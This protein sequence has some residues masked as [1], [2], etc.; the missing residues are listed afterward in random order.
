M[1]D[2]ER[3]DLRQD[4][5]QFGRQKED[6]DDEQDVVQT[7]RHDVL[8]A[9]D[10]KVADHV[11]DRAG[12][13]VVDHQRR[14]GRAVLQHLDMHRFRPDTDCAQGDLAVIRGPAECEGLG[15]RRQIARHLQR[16]DS[17]L[18]Q[19]RTVAESLVRKARLDPLAVQRE[20][21]LRKE[22]LLVRV[23]R[24]FHFGGGQG[25]QAV[26]FRRIRAFVGIGQRRVDLGQHRFKVHVEL[27]A[28][29]RRVTV[30]VEDTFRGLE[31]M[32]CGCA[33]QHQPCQKRD[34]GPET[35]NPARSKPHQNKSNTA[36]PL[37]SVHCRNSHRFTHPT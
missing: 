29:G 11:P 19:V 22:F 10:K 14:A 26:V 9:D 5:A 8:I 33:R 23:E 12:L 3:R 32:R 27:D 30:E 37:K 17:G 24:R 15:A 21:E 6:A 7:L 18:G 2:G 34:H 13:Q 28:E 20:D 36:Q 31:N 1:R 25:P 4:R 16:R 35:W